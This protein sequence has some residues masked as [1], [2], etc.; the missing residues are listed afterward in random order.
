I[1]LS[2]KSKPDPVGGVYLDVLIEL[3]SEDCQLARFLPLGPA[4]LN[5]LPT[6]ASRTF[7]TKSPTAANSCTRPPLGG[8][9][10]SGSSAAFAVASASIKAAASLCEMVPAAAIAIIFSISA[11]IVRILHF[12]FFLAALSR[13]IASS[14]LRSPRS[15]AARMDIGSSNAG[16][17]DVTDGAV[18]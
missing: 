16:V 13:S 11:R 3:P 9:A 12:K 8:K 7:A 14:A 17:A 10:A 18:G 1:V 6:D 15:R 2:E 4:L 5:I